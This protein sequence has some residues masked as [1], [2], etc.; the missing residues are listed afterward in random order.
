MATTEV[1][2][3]CR[4]QRHVGLNDVRAGAECLKDNRVCR[5]GEGNNP[6]QE[7]V[8]SGDPRPEEG[9]GRTGSANSE[10]RGAVGA[11]R[12][13]AARGPIHRSDP[14]GRGPRGGG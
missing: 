8:R 5:V 14:L 6:S 1:T 4:R 10:P 7:A 9:H 11:G 3:S 13:G 12:A 2:V